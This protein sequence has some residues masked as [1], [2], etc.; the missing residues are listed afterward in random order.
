MATSGDG[1]VVVGSD[2]GKIRLYSEKTLTQAKTAIPGLGLP[3]TNVDVTYD[4]KW[5]LATTRSYLMVLKTTYRD[6]KSGKELCGFT[7]KMGANAPAPRLLRLKPEDVRLTAGAGGRPAPLEKGHFTW[8]TERGSQ[9]RWIVASCGNYTVL[10]NF[11]WVL[12]VEGVA[13]Q[14][15]MACRDADVGQGPHSRVC[16]LTEWHAVHWQATVCKHVAD[17]L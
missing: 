16:I 14:Q 8:I 6:S 3:I 1:Y 9:E 10:W 17:V 2:D 11:R 5:V 15:G 12:G 7:S 4:G 13:R